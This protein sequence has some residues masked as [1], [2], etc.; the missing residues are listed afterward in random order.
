MNSVSLQLQQYRA[1][2]AQVNAE[3]DKTVT[4]ILVR[5]PGKTD[6]FYKLMKRWESSYLTQTPAKVHETA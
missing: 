3:S 4:D 6:Y 1:L 5:H 2:K